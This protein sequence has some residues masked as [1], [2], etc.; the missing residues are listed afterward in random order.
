[1]RVCLKKWCC[2]IFSITRDDLYY[3]FFPS[4]G[5]SFLVGLGVGMDE[6]RWTHLSVTTEG[7]ESDTESNKYVARDAIFDLSGG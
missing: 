7:N 5:C 1:M 2:C 4:Y 3:D 6:S